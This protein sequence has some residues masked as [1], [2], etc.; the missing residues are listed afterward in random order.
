M[1]IPLESDMAASSRRF[2]FG[3]AAGAAISCLVFRLF[4]I[5]HTIHVFGLIKQKFAS[6]IRIVLHQKL[7]GDAFE[8]AFTNH[9]VRDYLFSEIFD[10]F[11]IFATLRE[12]E[13]ELGPVRERKPRRRGELVDRAKECGPYFPD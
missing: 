12:L 1:T 13:G 10:E 5:P 6:S 9:R 7:I 4:W 2:M 8:Q 3:A 11:R